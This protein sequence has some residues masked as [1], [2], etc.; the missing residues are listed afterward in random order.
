MKRTKLLK[1]LHAHGCLFERE[2]GNYTISTSAVGTRK[3]S[4]PRHAEIKSS[5]TREICEDVAVPP[6]DER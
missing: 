4:V 2:G 3:T 1:H 6:P 5:L